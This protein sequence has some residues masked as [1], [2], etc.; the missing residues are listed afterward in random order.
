MVFCQQLCPCGTSTIITAALYAE[1]EELV[2]KSLE[3]GRCGALSKAEV[4]FFCSAGFLP[5][6]HQLYPAEIRWIS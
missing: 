3:K 5:Q 2:E 6:L 4:V 1:L